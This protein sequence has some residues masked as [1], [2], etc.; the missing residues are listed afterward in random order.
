MLIQV[1]FLVMIGLLTAIAATGRA[2]NKIDSLKAEL[3]QTTAP[4]KRAE[5]L[6]VISE[7]FFSSTRYDSLG[8]YADELLALGTRLNSQEISLL[9]GA[10]KAQSFARGDSVTFFK[11]AN[12]ALQQSQAAGFSPGVAISCLGLGSRL[13]TLGQYDQAREYL[14]RG[15]NAIDDR[16][17]L[18]LIGIK[19]DLIRTVSAVYHHQGRYTEALDYG[20]QS[21]R[22]AEKSKEAIQILKSYLN[23]S[24]L[25]GEL[26]SPENGLG[27]A[28]DRQRYHAEA[29]KYMKLS[30]ALSI[31]NASQRSQG[32]TAFNLGSLYAEDRQ[33]DSA[34]YYLNEAIRLGLTTNFHELLSNA[35]RAKSTLYVVNP[36]SA[37]YYL[38]L[39]HEHAALALNPITGIATSLD[40]VKILI[41]QKKWREAEI[42]ATKTLAGARELKL[43][44]DQRSAYQLL[45]EINVAQQRYQIALEHY[46]NFGILRDSITNEKNFAR[47]E[48]LKARYESDLKDSEIKELEQRGSIQAL[49]I[50]QKNFW[51]VGTAVAALLMAL[52]LFL[53]FRQRAL[54]QKQRALAIENRFLRFQLDPHFLSNALVSIQRFMLDNDAPRASQYLAKFSKLMRQ[55]LE[56]SRQDLISIEEEIDLLRNYLDIQ[57]LRM[58]ERFNYRIEVDPSLSVT[59]SRI[60]PMLAQPFV[61]NALEHGIGDRDNGN[62]V[63]SFSAQGDQLLLTIED[64][65]AGILLSQ[66]PNHKSLSTTI[67]HER[68][69]VLNQSAKQPIRLQI[70]PCATGSGTRVTL[71]LPIYS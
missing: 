66:N 60:P 68:I 65:G 63:I 41:L 16:A 27:T 43:L 1:R 70:G 57:K 17:A 25:Y 45:Y 11:Q 29:K 31:T 54:N 14:L 22:L 28:Q 64:D 55:L 9:A 33:T 42:L 26:S 53:Y 71:T 47:I 35:Y 3:R 49:E 13:L 50:R 56:Y 69:A 15:F 2:Q 4:E 36:D 51:L 6:S 44:N 61:E 18:N 10:Y 46:I 38:D 24:G 52:I 37:L 48:E 32:A 30:Y 5:I 40:K 7:S 39:A 20:L 62:I 23:L 58:K 12:E 34:R 19:S 67:I 59:D 21:S 8:K